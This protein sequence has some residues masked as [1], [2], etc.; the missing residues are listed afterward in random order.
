M[1]EPSAKLLHLADLLDR[2]AK[3][4]DDHAAVLREHLARRDWAVAAGLERIA[5]QVR[6][7]AAAIREGD[8]S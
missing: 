2:T 5:Q 7:T 1:T 6:R 3:M 4:H 8:Y